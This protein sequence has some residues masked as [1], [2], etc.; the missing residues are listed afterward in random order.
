MRV[1]A[2]QIQLAEGQSFRVLRWW[3]SV[4]EVEV[5]LGPNHFQ[6]MRGE[7][8]RWHYHNALELTCFTSGEGARFVGDQ[9]SP[10]AAGDL[11]LLGERLPHYW[12]ARGP[13]SGISVQWEFPP[14][15]AFWGF[16]EASALEPLFHEARRGLKFSG[17]IVD[18]LLGKM[19]ALL[20]ASP[21]GRLAGLFQIFAEMAAARESD[22]AHLS[23]RAFALAAGN[24]CRQAMAEAVRHLLANYRDQ[25]R[26]EDLLQLTG[27]SKATFSRQF[28]KHS[29]KTF[30]DFVSKIRLE[31]TCRDLAE[32]DKTVLE[33]ALAHGFSQVSYFNRLFR[34]AQRCSPTEY[35]SRRR[36]GP[37]S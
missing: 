32:T 12:H 34:R 28:K 20:T 16:P 3:R 27:M 11:V 8:A 31:A 23:T 33:I 15:H 7:G 13:S 6:P 37:A 21:A 9:I 14:G 1:A 10:F 2:E 29:G 24:G 5:C 4:G 22:R 19:Q 17:G 25:I 26:L 30:S 18:S 35:R 36:A